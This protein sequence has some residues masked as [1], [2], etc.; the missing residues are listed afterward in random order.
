MY[1][2]WRADPLDRPLFSK[3]RKMLEKITERFPESFSKEDIIYI[4]TS[5]QDESLDGEAAEHPVLSSS[6]SC[7]HQGAENATVTAD[8]HGS[9]E[10][11]S[12]DGR[13][14][15]VIS[16]DISPRSPTL[17]TPLLS[18]DSSSRSNGNIVPDG[19]RTDHNSSD[20]SHLL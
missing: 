14:V 20:I 19:T 17:D 12:D 3:L 18:S 9:M 2:C 11:D 10:D 8:V 7:S 16:P 4:N 6:P 15:V 13:Y 5:F 1:S